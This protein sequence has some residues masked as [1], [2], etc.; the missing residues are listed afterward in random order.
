MML[1][2][3]WTVARRECLLTWRR[4]LDWINPLLFFFM[5][6]ILLPLS[7]AP[8][9]QILS[10]V[11]AGIIWVAALLA[12]LLSLTRLFQSDYE[13]GSLEQWFFSPCPLPLL[14]FAKVTAHWVM[15]V[16]PLL[17]VIPV[18]SLMFHLTAEIVGV[19]L[20]TLLLGAP[21][22]ILLGAIGAALTLSLPHQGLFLSL[23]LLPLYIPPLIFATSAISAVM[24]GQSMA[25]SIAWMGALLALA[26]V[27]APLVTAGCL[28]LGVAFK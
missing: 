18:L 25:G 1:S 8:D 21:L 27:L 13:D 23:I 7:I 2:F 17:I 26:V 3:F 12:I 28:R 9:S 11:G 20:I 10:K 15:V 14:I 6:V 5:V 16:I 4:P 22:L 19:L 24:M